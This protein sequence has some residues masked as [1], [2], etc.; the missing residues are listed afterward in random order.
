LIQ[1]T[2]IILKEVTMTTFEML[3]KDITKTVSNYK[4]T[5]TKDEK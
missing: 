3:E 5:R 1:S 2:I 4:I